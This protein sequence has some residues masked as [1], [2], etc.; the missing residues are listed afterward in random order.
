MNA[1]T[2]DD[3]DNER[4]RYQDRGEYDAQTNRIPSFQFQP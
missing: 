2:A 3:L 4:L 1:D